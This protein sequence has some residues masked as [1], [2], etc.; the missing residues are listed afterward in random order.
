MSAQR[1]DVTEVVR[2]QHKDVTARLAAVQHKTGEDRNH[3]F[4]ALVEILTGHETA[5]EAV[6]YPVL[7]D[8]GDNGVK[9]ADARTSEEAA[10]TVILTH[11]QTLDT[12]SSEFMT[13]FTDFA[14]KVH[15]HAAHEEAE[16][17]PLLTS[18]IT[19]AQRFEM[20]R[21]FLESEQHASSKK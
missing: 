12:N 19:E 17:L 2:Q 18:T 4:R 8:I 13:A 11:L 10:A 14:D 6:I 15:Q 3:E 7:R 9:I 16:V 5:E 21:A 1:N 20:G